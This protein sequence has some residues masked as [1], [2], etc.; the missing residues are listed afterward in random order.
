MNGILIPVP[1]DLVARLIEAAG[2][3]TDDAKQAA[4]LT[5]RQVVECETCSGLHEVSGTGGY[6]CDAAE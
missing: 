4:A 1:R 3:D 2:P 5:E 6:W